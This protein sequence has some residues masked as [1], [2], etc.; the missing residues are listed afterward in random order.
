MPTITVDGARIPYRVEG[1][2]PALVLVHGVGPGAAMW[3]GVLDRFT[4]HRTV[5]RPDLA[6]S[7]AASDDGAPLTAGTLAAQ[8]A[9][10]IEDAGTGRADVLGF[11]LGAPVAAAVAALR[12]DLVRRLVPVAGVAGPGDEYVRQLVA[13][14][15][16]AAGDTDAFARHSTL[17]AYSRGFMNR[18]GHAAVEQAHA[19]MAPTPDRLRQV[20]LVGRIDVR[21]LLPRI[22][23]PTLVIGA[24]H[25]ATLPVENHREF[26][27]GIAGA[28]Y[29]ELDSGHVVM[30]ERTDEFLKLVE[31]F[32]SR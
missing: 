29:A 12:P 27:T 26:S 19:F 16:A 22:T 24:L 30:G 18:A 6:G 14:W 25:D 31:D 7:D 8:V 11:S 1:T 32:L 23:A 4:G 5:V 28:E 15:L 3:D 21:D 10:V 9:A 17:L 2:G 20:D 13:S